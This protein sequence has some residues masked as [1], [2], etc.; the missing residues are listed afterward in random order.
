MS[1]AGS[2]KATTPPPVR[3]H[4][5]TANSPA[6]AAAAPDNDN[7]KE[8]DKEK[9]N[10]KDN[11]N[12]SD[13]LSDIDE[14]VFEEEYNPDTARVE[15]RDYEDI[16]KSLKA[17]KRKRPAGEAA[18]K[19][20]EGRREKK[21]RTAD[22]DDDQEGGGGDGSDG[23]AEP[24]IDEATLTPEE[25]R[26]RALMRA[27][28]AATKNPTKRRRKK[29]EVDLEE[30]ADEEI[31]ELK[32]SMENACVVDN[33]ARE[34]GKPAVGKLKLL[35]RVL[36]MMNRTSI[37]H[38]ILDPE[39]NF[40]QS[41]RFFLEPLNDGSLPAYNIQSEIFAALTRLPIGKE[42]LL[43]S[44]IGKV[45]LFYTKSTR[46]E[47]AVKRMAEKLVGEWSR[48]I[49]K[50]T[51]D[52]RK[53]F[54]QTREFDYTAAKNAQ[55]LAAYSNSQSSQALP[56]LPS[57]R[58]A[59]GGVAVSSF[60]REIQKKLAPETESSRA[61]PPGLPQ[62]YTIAPQSTFDGTSRTQDYRPI[63]AGGMEAFRKMTQKGKGGRRG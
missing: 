17:S 18:R 6:A 5:D 60:E 26:K 3:D 34:E 38:A 37:Q 24:E 29:D 14:D 33:K 52:F 36:S 53:R 57:Q 13:V 12:D 10:D 23:D 40:L 45:V 41:V 47:P 11:D 54:I 20:K 9:D 2:E 62:T 61:R 30:Q 31:A 39:T 51:D 55:E 21:R 28:D 56:L 4:D 15:E 44:G 35:P 42:A 46:P 1:D 22:Q 63:G 32:I 16:A 7:E 59:G 43:S 25:R 8:S 19:P 58:G 48:P 27:M 50:R 49:L